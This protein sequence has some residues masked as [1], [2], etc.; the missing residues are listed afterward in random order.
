LKGETVRVTGGRRG[1]EPE[2]VATAWDGDR[3]TLVAAGCDIA[4][5]RERPA[6]VE[7]R[8]AR[9]R[10]N[11]LVGWAQDGAYRFLPLVEHPDFGLTLRPFDLC[12]NKIL[13]LV[14]RLEIRVPRPLST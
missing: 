13:A 10:E 4:V 11:V 2:A 9:G 8:I 5:L 1:P 7:A 6:Y 12:T 3:E 14:G